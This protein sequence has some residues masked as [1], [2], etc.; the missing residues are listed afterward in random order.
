MITP[1][2]RSATVKAVNCRATTRNPSD[3]TNWNASW[4]DGG[5]ASDDKA[6]SGARSSLPSGIQF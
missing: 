3:V 1:G 5:K 4:D 2:A 6:T